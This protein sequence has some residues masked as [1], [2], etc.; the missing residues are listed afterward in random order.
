MAQHVTSS[1]TSP[2]RSPPP[3]ARPPLPAPR[4]RRQW[5]PYT[6]TPLSLTSSNQPIRSCITV[7]LSWNFSAETIAHVTCVQDPISTLSCTTISDMGRRCT[8][9][10]LEEKNSAHRASALRY[11]HTPQGKEVRSSYRSLQQRRKVSKQATPT[12]LDRIP[13]LPPLSPAILTWN[14]CALPETESLYQAAFTA[15]AWIDLSDLGRW[16]KLPLFEEDDD[17]TDPYSE[18]YRRFTHNLTLV[19]H[20]DRMRAQNESD[21]LRRSTF[22]GAG[23]KA[24]LE[25]LREE[26]AEMIKCWDRSR[27]H[28]MFQHYLQWL[29]STIY[30]LYYLEFLNQPSV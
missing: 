8:H 29:A 11:S 13:H 21:V 9:L 20:G 23:A 28:T 4:P 24:A 16:K 30:P 10:T 5:W 17:R 25:R 19:L 14:E 3:G 2:P 12:P 22:E 7:N 18:S 26:V 1:P 6:F 27:E 15:A